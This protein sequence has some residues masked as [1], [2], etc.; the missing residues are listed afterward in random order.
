MSEDDSDSTNTISP[1]L[2]RKYFDLDDECEAQILRLQIENMNAQGKVREQ[3]KRQFKLGVADGLP[4][5]AF[6]L[7]LKRHRLDIKHARQQ[8][9][10]I[11]EQ[12]EDVVELAD[13]IREK[14]GGYQDT[15]LGAAAVAKA[16][17]AETK[18]AKRRGAK[19]KAL[20]DLAAGDGGDDVRPRHLRD[21]EAARTA[22]NEALL[23]A[24]IKP[25]AH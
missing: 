9:N 25:L 23:K 21:A 16:E 5:E 19:S 14:L 2:I 6:R 22:D 8:A 12:E 7:E 13:L 18:V 4:K 17:T 15:P 10:L 24:G 20:D 1:E 3:Q 11:A